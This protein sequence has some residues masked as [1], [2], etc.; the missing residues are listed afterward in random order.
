[1]TPTGRQDK[2]FEEHKNEEI[3]SE[4]AFVLMPGK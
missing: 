2:A 1:M 4:K 3:R